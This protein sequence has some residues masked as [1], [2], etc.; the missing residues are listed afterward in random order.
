MIEASLESKSTEALK[1][2]GFFKNILATL[3]CSL[4]PPLCNETSSRSVLR[5]VNT[6][7][8]FEKNVNPVSCQV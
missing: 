5:T 4:I 6:T 1:A 7:I 3:P 2:G 8:G